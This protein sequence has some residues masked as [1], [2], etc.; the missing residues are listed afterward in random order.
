MHSLVPCLVTGAAG[1]IASHLS[2]ALAQAGH[3]VV[4]VDCFD[5]YYD[6]RLK[7]RNLECVCAHPG[8]SFMQGDVCDGEMLER[9]FAEHQPR[10][11]FHLAARAGVRGS[12]QDP[13]LYTRMNVDA[14]V[15]LLEAARKHGVE[16][17][18]LASSSSVYGASNSLPFSEDQRI[19]KPE[20]P[21]A[22]TKVAA[23]ALSYTYSRIHKL[24]VTC[25]R[26]FTVY[27]PRQRPDLAISKFVG[28]MLQDKPIPVY[29]DG[30]AS[31]DF[32]FVGDI[33][34]GI[35]ATMHALELGEPGC[36]EVI[37]LGSDRPITVLQMVEG[38]EAALGQKAVIDWQ[39]PAPGDVPHTWASVEKAG[40]L[41][42][43]KPQ[44]SLA[45]GLSAFVDWYR[46]SLA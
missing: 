35:V 14:T 43:W 8:F 16:R 12:I 33:V 7:R 24:P 15:T 9:V 25:L 21:Y 13:E 39:P 11:V 42:Q 34:R 5:P 10:I 27:G 31:R 17:F 22:A 19:D 32:T 4:G 45:D 23:E 26:F 44:T 37:N 38:I 40:R 3:P 18:V 46:K 28:L 36:F 41:L 2:E 29:G 20:S 6:E 30:T 1:F